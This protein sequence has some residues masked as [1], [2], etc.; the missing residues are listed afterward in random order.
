M[1]EIKLNSSLERVWDIHLHP[2]RICDWI[3]YKPAK[4]Y[5]WGLIS[6]GAHYFHKIKKKRISDISDEMNNIGSIV[7][8]YLMIDK[9]IVYFRPCVILILA[10][11]IKKNYEF[12]T[13]QEAVDFRDS[14]IHN[15]MYVNLYGL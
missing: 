12:D 4:K 15:R 3:E 10:G 1:E 11:S 6:V 2:R 8:S 14:I 7:G 9:N 13:D 5:L